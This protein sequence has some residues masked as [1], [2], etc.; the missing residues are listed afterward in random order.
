L[1]VNKR[2]TRDTR[3]RWGG[4]GMSV[5][6]YGNVVEVFMLTFLWSA[7]INRAAECRRKGGRK[8][9]FHALRK[10]RTLGPVQYAIPFCDVCAVRRFSD[11]NKSRRKGWPA[12]TQSAGPSAGHSRGAVSGPLGSRSIQEAP[13]ESDSPEP[14][15]MG[16]QQR[17]TA[18]SCIRLARRVPAAVRAALHRSKKVDETALIRRP[19]LFRMQVLPA[20][21]PWPLADAAANHS[22]LYD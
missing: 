7:K 18:P 14:R 11:A 5:R 8:I 2:P 20:T 6:K 17:A 9:G 12:A 4:R 15:R 22:R 1:S 3:D 10:T 21:A 19:N 16:A 13:A